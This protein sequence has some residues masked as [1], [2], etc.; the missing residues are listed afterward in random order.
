MSVSIMSAPRRWGKIERPK[1]PAGKPAT[2]RIL[3]LRVGQGDGFIRVKK[4]R[5][6]YFH[7]ADLRD[8]TAFNA[9]QV[10][11]TVTFELIEDA[12]SGARATRVAKVKR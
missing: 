6:I 7:R 10:G 8:G 2:G 5:E 1:D 11:D 4:S 12:V 9:L 3:H